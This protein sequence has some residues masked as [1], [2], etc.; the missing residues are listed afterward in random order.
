MDIKYRIISVDEKEGSFV[1]RYF[2]DNDDETSLASYF[3]V[4]G[5]IIL[6]S[7]GYPA[8]CRTDVNIALNTNINPS[9]NDIETLIAMSSP[10]QWFMTR[11]IIRSNNGYSLSN[12]YSMLNHVN[13]FEYNPPEKRLP[14]TN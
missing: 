6:D 12:V 8:R 14:K 9:A 5:E 10:G 7:N 4:D 1:V 2:T 3:D 11:D 13:T